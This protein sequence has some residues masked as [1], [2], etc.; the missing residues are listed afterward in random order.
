MT[1]PPHPDPKAVEACGGR[2]SARPPVRP[3]EPLPALGVGSS[4]HSG[5]VG[6]APIGR[7]NVEALLHAIEQMRVPFG[8]QE[9]AQELPAGARVVPETRA[10]A[11]ER[12]PFPGG[13]R[14]PVAA[15]EKTDR[16]VPVPDPSDE[17]AQAAQ[18]GVQGAEELP[19]PSGEELLPDREPRREP[20]EVAM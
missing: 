20:A 10:V 8:S 2:S 15:L 18:P 5:Q 17:L 13:R 11:L 14:G 4:E 1:D 12:L 7:S 16:D 19:I 3:V 9:R 6:G